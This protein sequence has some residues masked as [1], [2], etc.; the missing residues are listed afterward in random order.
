M[1]VVISVV[2]IISLA[3]TFLQMKDKKELLCRKWQMVGFKSF[4][5]PYKST[6]PNS[7]EILQFNK[8]GTYEEEM[9]NLKSEGIWEFNSDSTKYKVSLIKFNGKPVKDMPLNEKKPINVIINLTQDS[10][11]IG[12]EAYFRPDK[13]S[14]HDDR[15][16]IPAAK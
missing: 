5:K 10:L 1:K 14:G 15:Y 8:N 16:Y 2:I 6:N 4:N 12:N 7:T 3:F 9:Y 11:I 13:I